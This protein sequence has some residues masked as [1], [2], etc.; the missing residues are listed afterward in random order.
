M[1][2]FGNMQYKEPQGL[3]HLSSLKENPPSLSPNL[4]GEG[5]TLSDATAEFIFHQPPECAS[6][7]RSAAF[8]DLFPRRQTLRAGS[9]RRGPALPTLGAGTTRALPAPGPGP[10]PRRGTLGGGGAGGT[11]QSRAA[12][13][14]LGSPSASAPSFLS[15]QQCQEALQPSFPISSAPHPLLRGLK[16]ERRESGR[17]SGGEMKC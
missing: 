10:P 15:G 9:N 1:V 6:S 12:A 7:V 17:P 8:C 16:R 14:D 5:E 11:V 13:A 3:G 4:K 2:Q